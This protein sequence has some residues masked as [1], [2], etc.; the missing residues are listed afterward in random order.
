MKEKKPPIYKILEFVRRHSLAVILI[1]VVIT[2]GFAA[3]LLQIRIDPDLESL[4]PEDEQVTE[5]M[6]KYGGERVNQNYFVFA[7][8]ADDPF[9]LEAL[10]AL[11][12]AITALEQLPEIREGVT[13]FNLVTFTKTKGRL[14]IQPL[15]PDGRAPRTTEQL[16]AFRSNI[17]QT[18]FAENLVVSADRSTLV[19]LFPVENTDNYTELMDEIEG[20]LSPLKTYYRTYTTGTIPFMKTTESY[21]TRDLSRLLALAVAL[22]LITFYLG[23]RAKRAVLLPLLIVLMGTVWCIGFMSLVGF[24]LSMI[25]VV[26]PPLVLALGSS[27]SIHILNQY[28]REGGRSSGDEGK[29]WITESITHVNRTI[30]LAGLTTIAGLLSLLAVSMRQTREFA[31]STAFGVAA[32]IVLSL[33]F[34]PALLFRLKDPKAK[35]SRQVL[36]GP[37]TRGITKLG[38]AALK[39]RYPIVA[40]LLVMVVLFVFAMR[41]IEYNTAAMSYFP[42]RARVVQDMRFFTE[43]IG[44]FEEISV[45]LTAPE[46]RTNYFLDTEVLERIARF[47]SSL[48]E[49]PDISYISSFVQYLKYLNQIMYGSYSVPSSRAPVLLLSRYFKILAAQDQNMLGFFANEDFS[50]ITITMRIYDSTEGAFIDEIGLRHLLR[51]IDEL[52]QHYLPPQITAERWGPILRYL[53]LSNVLKRDSLT[54]MIMAAAAILLITAAAFRSLR[55]GL[56]ALVPLAT[57]VMLNIIFM[58][59]FGIPLDMITIMVSSIAIG[60]GVDDSIHFLIQFRRQRS[61]SGGAVDTAIGKTLAITGRP[62]VL[63]SVSIIAGLLVLGFA[64]FRPVRY[65][66]FLVAFTLAAACVGTIVVLP[67][68]LSVGHRSISRKVSRT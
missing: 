51:R 26:I 66:G 7:S 14:G 41:R 19:C 48:A 58:V 36:E 42:R 61:L 29:R 56:Y 5:L 4:L 54:S 10:A 31:V 64:M 23:F 21:L 43:K 37:L 63:T 32:C 67:A 17:E 40:V 2:A 50:S 13:P 45:T 57:G 35:Q 16:D 3:A 9:T 39:L 25:S 47:E 30:L 49:I 11:D 65:F 34:F 59:A 22:I 53:S 52:E 1:C 28:F 20:I 15:S 8:E 60:V 44:G 6:R 12:R 24:P 27:Y 46:K 38:R 18:P 55:F 62:I 33:F 68:V